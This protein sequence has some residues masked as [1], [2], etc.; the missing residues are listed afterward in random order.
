[1]RGGQFIWSEYGVGAD[2]A[3]CDGVT[4]LIWSGKHSPHGT[5]RVVD[6]TG[7]PRSETSPY[8][9][10]GSSVQIA[11]SL[12]NRVRIH[13]ERKKAGVE[14]HYVADIESQLAK[15]Q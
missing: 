5:V 10:L 2:F 1:M 8:T 14:G 6:S 12:V 11:N 13:L 4:M 7:Q 3:Q 15:M 9:L